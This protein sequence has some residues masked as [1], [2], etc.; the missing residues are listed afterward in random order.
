[1]NSNDGVIG[2]AHQCPMPKPPN[3]KKLLYNILLSLA[4]VL[5]MSSAHFLRGFSYMPIKPIIEN[6]RDNVKKN[7]KILKPKLL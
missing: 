4:I 7:I 1:M 3:I 2:L 5:Y 6:V